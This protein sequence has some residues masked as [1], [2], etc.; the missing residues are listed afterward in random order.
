MASYISKI[1]VLLKINEL[2]ELGKID[3]AIRLQN[4]FLDS[5]KIDR[6]TSKFSPQIELDRKSKKT[7]ISV[8]LTLT[9]AST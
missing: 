4:V 7:I 2:K 3:E 6:N 8:G 9:S 1:E 5:I